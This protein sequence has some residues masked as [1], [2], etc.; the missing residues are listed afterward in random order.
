VTTRLAVPV[1]PEVAMRL[2]PRAGRTALGLTQAQLGERLGISAQAV[3]RREPAG[4]NPTVATL[5]KLAGV[6]GVPFVIE[7]APVPHRRPTRRRTAARAARTRST[8][9]SRPC[10]TTRTSPRMR[11]G[12]AAVARGGA[13]VDVI[14]DHCA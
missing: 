3:Q 5:A 1:P 2:T 11:H 13:H 8:V 6:L 14:A 4:T 12:G 7:A 9:P 10:A